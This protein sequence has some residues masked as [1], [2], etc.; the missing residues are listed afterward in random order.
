MRMVFAAFAVQLAV[1]AHGSDAHEQVIL[2]SDVAAKQVAVMAAV[3][4]QP[5]TWSAQM[6]WV[7]GSNTVTVSVPD[8]FDLPEDFEKGQW[9]LVPH[10]ETLHRWNRIFTFMI[11]THKSPPPEGWAKQIQEAFYATCKKRGTVPEDTTST[12]ENGFAV[13]EWVQSCA[14]AKSGPSKGKSETDIFRYIEGHDADLVVMIG[15]HYTPG[16]QEISDWRTLLRAST[17]Q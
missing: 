3:P 2:K 6:Q 12:T 10:G 11:L 9:E 15:F 17:L 4:A 8:G 1:A 16:P 5:V 13:S 14:R 7:I